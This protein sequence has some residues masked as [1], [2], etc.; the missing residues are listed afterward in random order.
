MIV[1]DRGAKDKTL[2]KWSGKAPIYPVCG[3]IAQLGERIVRNDEVV[4]SSPTSSTIFCSLFTD[5]DS[6]A[7]IIQLAQTLPSGDLLAVTCITVAR[8]WGTAR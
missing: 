8:G 6:V 5:P 3:A 7:R 1:R 4:G 2:L